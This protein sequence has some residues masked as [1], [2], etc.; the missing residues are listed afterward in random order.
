MKNQEI[1][2]AIENLNG[3]LKTETCEFMIANIKGKIS[4]FEVKNPK[5]KK[6]ITR[7]KLFASINSND[8]T[9]AYYKGFLS[10]LEML[11]LNK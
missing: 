8:T 2:K 6:L 11:N 5:S 7:I 9:Q 1:K 3:Y 10:A 4:G